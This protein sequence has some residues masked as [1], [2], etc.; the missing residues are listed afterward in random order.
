MKLSIKKS[1]FFLNLKIMSPSP[2]A[3]WHIVW[4]KVEAVIDFIFV[5]SKITVDSDPSHEIQRR[6]VERTLLQTLLLFSF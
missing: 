1:F 3:S 4:E 2:I 5:A 6:S